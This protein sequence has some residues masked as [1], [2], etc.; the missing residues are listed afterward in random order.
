[1][2][3]RPV[4]C[5]PAGELECKYVHPLVHMMLQLDIIPPGN[6]GS[7]EV[8][9]GGDVNCGVQKKTCAKQQEQEKGGEWARR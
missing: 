9:E 4:V 8:R 2:G 1:M 7:N 3:G 6:R 5:L